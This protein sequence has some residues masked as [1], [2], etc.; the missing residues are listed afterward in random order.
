M[1]KNIKKNL[2]DEFNKNHDQTDSE[3]IQLISHCRQNLNQIDNINSEFLKEIRMNINYYQ[4]NFSNINEGFE[5]YINKMK[6]YVERY[7]KDN[8]DDIIIKSNKKMNINDDVGYNED[9]RKIYKK[10]KNLNNFKK[11]YFIKDNGIISQTYFSQGNEEYSVYYEIKCYFHIYENSTDIRR[12]IQTIKRFFK[13]FVILYRKSSNKFL[14][15]LI[16]G[17]GF[18]DIKA[19]MKKL[20]YTI[21]NNCLFKISF[22]KNFDNMSDNVYTRI[23]KHSYYITINNLNIII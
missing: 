8:L 17:K 15:I 4:N 9:G 18:K 13:Q 23:N 11:L 21:K 16:I 2:I 22:L 19:R 20:L 1:R 10:V 14:K 5:D 6:N 3:I 12:Y 7:S